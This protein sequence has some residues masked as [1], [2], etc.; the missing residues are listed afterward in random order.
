VVRHG[1]EFIRRGFGGADVHAA[2]DQRRIDAD[3]LDA[4][5]ACAIAIAAAVLPEAVGP[6]MQM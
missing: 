1:G 4:S 5:S 2:V 3:D 6:A